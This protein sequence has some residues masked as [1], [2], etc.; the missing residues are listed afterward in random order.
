MSKLYRIEAE[1]TCDDAA[2]IL[3][4]MIEDNPN[5]ELTAFDTTEGTDR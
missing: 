1:V 3:R 2:Q 4:E 5:C